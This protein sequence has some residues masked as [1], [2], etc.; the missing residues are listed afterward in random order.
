MPD[1][2]SRPDA[3]P[4]PADPQSLAYARL[5]QRVAELE[6]TL[7]STGER[8]ELVYDAMVEQLVMQMLAPGQNKQRTPTSDVQFLFAQRSA[9]Y[10]SR[11]VLMARLAEVE[12]DGGAPGYIAILR[13][14]IEGY[15]TLLKMLDRSVKIAHE[16]G[17]VGRAGILVRP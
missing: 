2:A 11:N 16:A 4:T 5:E 17:E 7:A 13:G 3:K 8:A 14:V 6:K 1:S 10:A 15:E 9:A 12:K